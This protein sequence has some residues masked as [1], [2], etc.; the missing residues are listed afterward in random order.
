V[1]FKLRNEEEDDSNDSTESDEEVGQSTLVVRRSGQVR[2]L[3][4]RYIPPNFHYRFVLTATTEESKS[5]REAVDSI[6]G[7]L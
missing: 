1:R 6:K 7:R 4:K 2:K 3:V 5:I